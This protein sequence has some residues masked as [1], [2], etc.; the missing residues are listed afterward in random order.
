MQRILGLKRSPAVRT[1]WHP[2]R[3]RG[4]LAGATLALLAGVCLSPLAANAQDATWTGANSGDW[5]DPG[6]W[7]TTVPTGTATF[8]PNPT[9]ALF[10]TQAVNTIGTLQFNTGATGYSFDICFCQELHVTQTGV[11]DTVAT[12]PQ[13]F[14]DG[15]LL[16][17]ENASKAGNSGILEFRQH[18]FSQYRFGRQRL[19]HKSSGRNLRFFDSATAGNATITNNDGT[20]RFFNS[21]SAGDASILNQFNGAINFRD[22][23]TAG[24]AQITNTDDGTINFRDQSTAGTATIINNFFGFIRFSDTSNAGQ[25]NIHNNDDGFLRF[26]DQSS[27]GSATI[28]EQRL[29]PSPSNSARTAPPATPPS[30]NNDVGGIWHLS[31]EPTPAARR[32]S[33]TPSGFFG[34]IFFGE[35][36]QRR[37]RHDRHQQPRSDAC[38]AATAQAATRSSSRQRGHRSISAAPSAGNGDGQITRRLDR[39][40]RRLYHRR[41]QHD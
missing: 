4:V 6:N 8:D 32:S 12:A 26:A 16:S 5:N 38:S 39:G 30:R 18:R 14:V 17:F 21:S 34:G 9:N 25:A 33:T 1:M 13:L 15:G 40:R 11:V 29:R 10:F 3:G 23:S 27:A 7:T 28:N 22:T 19:H 2:R 31:V 20:I 35:Q 36:H 24:N 37:K 41:L